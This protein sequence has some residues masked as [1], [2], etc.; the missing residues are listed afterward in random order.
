MVTMR[1][2]RA[3]RVCWR[4]HIGALNMR[5]ARVSGQRQEARPNLS[6]TCPICGRPVVARCGEVRIWHWA[7]LGRRDCDPWSENKTKWHRRWQN[8]FPVEWQEVIHHAPSG[9]KHIADVK[10]DRGLVVEF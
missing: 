8:E 5:F 3:R 1:A 9:E 7:H 10:T 6:G 4:G 2:V